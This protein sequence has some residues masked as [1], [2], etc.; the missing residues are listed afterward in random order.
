MTIQRRM[1]L[2]YGTKTIDY[3]LV[4]SKRVKTSEIIVEKTKL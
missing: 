1:K 2:Y 3:L 4:K